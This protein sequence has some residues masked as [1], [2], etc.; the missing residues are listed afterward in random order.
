MR[1]VSDLF[2]IINRNRL[3]FGSSSIDR[4]QLSQDGQLFPQNYEYRVRCESPHGPLAWKGGQLEKKR[5]IMSLEL[6][7][8]SL[9]RMTRP[10]LRGMSLQGA[11]LRLTTTLTPPDLN[12]F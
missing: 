2:E 10:K 1:F 5:Y 4:P 11:P 12:T 3:K 9:H 6:K 8:H 7:H